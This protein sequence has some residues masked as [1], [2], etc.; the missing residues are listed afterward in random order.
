M[1][2]FYP[3]K[4]FSASIDSQETVILTMDSVQNAENF[5]NLT[6]IHRA[7]VQLLV[8]YLKNIRSGFQSVGYAIQLKLSFISTMISLTVLIFKIN[9]GMNL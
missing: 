6:F 8:D 1:N 2:N 3:E 4:L 9:N 5:Q 7:E